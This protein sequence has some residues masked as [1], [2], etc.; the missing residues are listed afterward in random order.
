MMMIFVP[1]K[2]LLSENT[3]FK[4]D[5]KV[6]YNNPWN[7][8]RTCSLTNSILVMRKALFCT[9]VSYFLGR[10]AQNEQF[11]WWVNRVLGKTQYPDIICEWWESSPVVM[12]WSNQCFAWLSLGAWAGVKGCD[13]QS[14][15]NNFG[16]GIKWFA[17]RAWL[18][19]IPR[20]SHFYPKDWS[21][22]NVM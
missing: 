13:T 22:G 11:H 9:F 3:T 10:R 5:L 15:W 12:N 19:G 1:Q 4:M 7:F 6:H 20:E 21:R 16:M 17:V 18:L 2:Y 8:E 14:L